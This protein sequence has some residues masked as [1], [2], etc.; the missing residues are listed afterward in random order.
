MADSRCSGDASSTLFSLLDFVKLRILLPKAMA[1][2][3]P[4]ALL[5]SSQGWLSPPRV[6]SFP[7]VLI[8]VPRGDPGWLIVDQ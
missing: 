4:R 5:S 6:T 2:R 3:S 7:T 8:K 1:K